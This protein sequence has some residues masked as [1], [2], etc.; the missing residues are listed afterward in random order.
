[1]IKDNYSD[2]LR[3]QAAF[4]DRQHATRGTQQENAGQWATTPN[5]TAVLF[6]QLLRARSSILE[7]GCANGRDARYW[8]TLLHEVFG[9]DFSSIALQQMQYWTRLAQL[10]DFITPILWNI[11]NGL[12]LDS[13]PIRMDAFYAR[14]SLHI[15]DAETEELA[16]QVNSILY[17]GGVICIE[18][19][20]P[21]DPKIKKSEVVGP[22]L[23]I[24]Y[25]EGGHLRRVWTREYMTGLC[26]ANNWR[27]VS[28]EET[29]EHINGD[30]S[31]FI[32]LLARKSA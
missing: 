14:S 26:T 31:S 28:L 18:G 5:E 8:A 10:T 3:I 16:H 32:R 15:P 11:V 17:P 30:T 20:G 24:N 21:Q 7:A 29:S 27:I 1:M 6:A 19:K 12:P 9:I 13:L 2:L 23:V 25:A 22:H 4:W